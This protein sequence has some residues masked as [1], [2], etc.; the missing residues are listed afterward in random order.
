MGLGKFDQDNL[1]RFR[2]MYAEKS[3]GQL[4][5]RDDGSIYGIPEGRECVTGK[6]ITRRDEEGKKDGGSKVGVESSGRQGDTDNLLKAAVN[7]VIDEGRL[8]VL[9]DAIRNNLS[10][11]IEERQVLQS[12]FPEDIVNSANEG[13]EENF[14]NIDRIIEEH[15]TPF[16]IQAR[17]IALD[18]SRDEFE[19]NQEAEAEIQ[20]KIE[21]LQ[22]N[23]GQLD[24]E[25]N[26]IFNELLS[27]GDYQRA[28]EQA[29]EVVFDL[30][31]DHPFSEEEYR[32]SL[33]TLFA[34]TNNSVTTLDE[35]F[36]GET[37]AWAM[38]PS[39]SEEED[40]DFPGTIDVG[41]SSDW[42]N[43]NQ[44][45]YHEFGHHVEFSNQGVAE[46]MANWV[47][48]RATSTEPVSLNELSGLSSYG[49]SEV[50]LPGNYFDP[51]VS[52][53][54][55]DSSGLIITE[56]FSIGFQYFTDPVSMQILY[57]RDPEHFRLIVG[58]LLNL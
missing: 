5:Q 27:R 53:V 3:S 12:A 26:S 36:Y 30:P 24:E 43:Q 6:P 22:Q 9:R 35:V 11:R 33:A 48:S 23:L 34:L 21:E 42:Y 38:P 14:D 50:A 7:E 56:A 32:N 10:Q 16:D 45:F 28:Q 44:V 31:P 40:L 13:F 47:L 18:A 39:R 37:R 19:G 54:Y 46:A 55:E 52:K 4:C 51:Y 58:A 8:D 17:I 57:E 1:I 20:R 15:G 49:E 25:F 41:M 29:E 2:E